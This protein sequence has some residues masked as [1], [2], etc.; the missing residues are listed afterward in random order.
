MSDSSSQH[1]TR[2]QDGHVLHLALDRLDKKNA[3]TRAMYTALADELASAAEDTT[4]RVVV[5]SGRQGVFTAGNDLLDFMADPPTGPES[6]VFRFLMQAVAFPKPFVV[7]V[8][9]PAIGIG[10]TILL[11]ADLV[12]AAEDARLQMPFAT[13]GLV[14]EAASSLLLPRLAG[15]V[16]AAELLMFGEPFSAATAHEVTRDEVIK[17]TGDGVKTDN[18]SAG[19]EYLVTPYNGGDADAWWLLADPAMYDTIEVG[20]L[21]GKRDPELFVQNS[22]T[23]GSM[24]DADKVTWKLRHIYGAALLDFRTFYAGIPA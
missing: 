5:L 13:L 4:V 2:S 20:F 8:E 1:V 15:H 21:D 22:E 14:P 10:T 17:R 19:I 23:V 18:F 7:A 12:Y 3:I 24:F 6:P 16:R 11:H 9:G